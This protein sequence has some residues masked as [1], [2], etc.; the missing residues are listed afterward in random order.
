MPAPT[1]NFSGIVGTPATPQ[2]MQL[3]LNGSTLESNGLTKKCVNI[4]DFRCIAPIAGG[5]EATFAAN[6]NGIIIAALAPCATA[7]YTLNT[8]LS[9]FMDNPVNAG[10]LVVSGVVGTGAGDRGPSFQA[11]VIRKLSGLSGRN[12]RGSN[13]FGAIP[14]GFTTKDDLNVTGAAAFA[15]LQAALSTLLGGVTDGVNTFYPIILSPTLSTLTANPRIFGGSW[16]QSFS[17][18]ARLGTMKRRKERS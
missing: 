10:T 14:E 12:Y 15:A 1:A 3:T 6:V 5:N 4:L 8:Y 7:D 18:N 2:F 9:R 16:V 17:V 13:H 11:A